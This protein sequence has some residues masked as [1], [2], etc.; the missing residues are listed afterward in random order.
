MK[1]RKLYV[2]SQKQK[3]TQKGKRVFFETRH[4]KT[5]EPNRDKR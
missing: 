2:R 1:R 4:R 5:K 3:E